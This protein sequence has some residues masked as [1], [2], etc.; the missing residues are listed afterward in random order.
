VPL[1]LAFN[2]FPRGFQ[3]RVKGPLGD[4]IQIGAILAAAILGAR[5]AKMDITILL[6]I[7]AIF[8][9]G[10]SLAM[11]TSVK[12]VI[13]SVKLM[14]FGYYS[15]GDSITIKEY[16]G[17]VI[18]ISL[19]ATTLHVSAKGLVIISNSKISD[20]DIVN[21]S[22]V[23][24]ELSVRV[25]ISVAHDRTIMQA[26]IRSK[27]A[28][29]PGIIIGSIKTVHAWEP[30]CCEVYTIRFKIDNYENRHDIVSSVSMTITNELESI[31]IMTGEVTF[32][33]DV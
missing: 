25:P 3:R 6:A 22:S 9:A 20:S 14:I 32:I 15:I 27:V 17:K 18:D 30:G 19:F 2:L 11:D 29:I 13:A 31:G 28:E 21:H 1:R 12:D 5:Y 8:T 33:R 7:V 26:L 16:S 10:V 4:I 24:I 23:P